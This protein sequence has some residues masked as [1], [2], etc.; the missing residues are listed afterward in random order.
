M[1]YDHKTNIIISHLFENIST[2]FQ[3]VIPTSF[4]HPFSQKKHKKHVQLC[5]Q[6]RMF[7]RKDALNRVE[8]QLLDVGAYGMGCADG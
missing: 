8:Q 7:A 5:R 4:H 3:E 6:T 2:H 1:G